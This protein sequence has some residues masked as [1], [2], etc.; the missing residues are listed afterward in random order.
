MGA[1]HLLRPE[2][3]RTFRRA[4]ARGA[5]LIVV[6]ASWPAVRDDHWVTL[7]KARAIENLAY[8]VGVNRCGQDP[9]HYHPGAVLSTTRTGA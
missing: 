9:K 4:A 7:L 3:P 5:N 2:I 6:I 1:I 8:V